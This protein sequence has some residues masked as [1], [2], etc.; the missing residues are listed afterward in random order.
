MSARIP[1]PLPS[2]ISLAATICNVIK[3]TIKPAAAPS[4]ISAAAAKAAARVVYRDRSGHF[5]IIE[6]KRD[7]GKVLAR[8]RAAKPR[9]LRN[10][11]VRG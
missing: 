9:S 5:V 10:G 6:K 3:R 8:G 11:S 7:T 1:Q 2:T 4:S